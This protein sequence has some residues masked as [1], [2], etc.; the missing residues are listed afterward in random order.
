MERMAN[1]KTHIQKKEH[2]NIVILGES[3]EGYSKYQY[4]VKRALEL[5]IVSL[6]VIV[7]SPLVLY[8]VYRIKKESKGKILF[9]QDRVGL[10]GKI[11]T[12]YKFRSMDEESYHNPYTEE[13]DKRI[14]PFGSIMRRMRIDELPQLWNVLKGEMHLIGPR[15]EWD[16]LAKEYAH[17]IPNYYLRHKVKPGI[18][19]LAQV[20]YP[21]GRNLQ[22]AKNKLKYDLLYI[23]QWS[24]GLEMIVLW[25][26]VMVVLGKKG[27]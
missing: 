16:I 21:Y 12:C 11:F 23:K 7:T 2:T 5:F 8:V 10:N 22:D 14:F 4:R 27:M 20:Y 17:Q 15:A 9:K 25:K 1:L 18:T 19:G 3:L 24:L 6:L 26:T 13:N